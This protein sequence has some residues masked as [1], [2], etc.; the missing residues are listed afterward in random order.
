MK[1]KLSH[2]TALLYGIF[3][4][5]HAWNIVPVET[6]SKSNM[7]RFNNNLNFNIMRLLRIYLIF[8]I[9]CTIM[10]GL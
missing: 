6:E 9:N 4:N 5:Y 10:W 3:N 8:F 7:E 2:L 1:D